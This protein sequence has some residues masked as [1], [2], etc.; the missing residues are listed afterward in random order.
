[1]RY[2]A[3]LAL[4][5]VF[6]TVSGRDTYVVTLSSEGFHKNSSLLVTQETMV[7]VLRTEA[8]KALGSH[9]NSIILLYD[10]RQLQDDKQLS[11]Y[12]INERSSPIDIRLGRGLSY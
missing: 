6:V 8:S 11:Y 12:N 5:R 10:G 3:S 9:E 2:L 1:M 7:S 4:T